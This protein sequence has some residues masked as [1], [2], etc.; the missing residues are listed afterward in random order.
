MSRAFS[1]PA[2]RGEPVVLG[3]LPA[4]GNQDAGLVELLLDALVQCRSVLNTA[5][6]DYVEGSPPHRVI[7]RK[8]DTASTAINIA[9]SGA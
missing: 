7:A 9:R 6:A 3:V 5:L 8:I 2:G 4:R 1:S